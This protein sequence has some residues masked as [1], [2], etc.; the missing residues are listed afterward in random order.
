MTSDIASP[1]HKANPYPFYARLRPY[2]L[3][4]GTDIDNSVR[5]RS[6]DPSEFIAQIPGESPGICSLSSERAGSG[7]A[8]G[9][10]TLR[11]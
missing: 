1:E 11:G 4:R 7:T 2:V 3:K 8:D 5:L 6:W 10:V 9:K